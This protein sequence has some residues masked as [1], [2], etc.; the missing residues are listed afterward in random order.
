MDLKSGIPGIYWYTFLNK[1]ILPLSIKPSESFPQVI[2]LKNFGYEII[3]YPKDDD[4]SSL[5]QHFYKRIINNLG[6][7]YIFDRNDK[8]RQYLVPEIIAK[9]K[10]NYEEIQNSKLILP[11][12]FN[13]SFDNKETNDVSELAENFRAILHS[14][15]NMHLSYSIE[16]LKSI[17]VHHHKEPPINNYRT[18]YLLEKYIPAFGGFIGQMLILHFN[19]KWETKK[20]IMKS[21]IT[22]DNKSW[23]EISPFRASYLSVF[24]NLRINDF[25]NFISST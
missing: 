12:L 10:A 22:L 4:D 6:Q 19:G 20:P 25:I 8:E 16:S 9:L 5:N 13:S 23:Y 1:S 18:H 2:Q 7:D 14:N 24:D 17:D 21:T 11:F 15:A 3:L